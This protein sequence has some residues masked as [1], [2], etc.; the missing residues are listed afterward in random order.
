MKNELDFKPQHSSI[1]EIALSALRLVPVSSQAPSRLLLLAK[2]RCIQQ[3]RLVSLHSSL[4]WTFHGEL[5]I[6]T[7]RKNTKHTTVRNSS[8]QH[9]SRDEDAISQF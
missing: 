8:N 7:P 9:N 6:F 2:S 4:R 1:V 5:A 3:E